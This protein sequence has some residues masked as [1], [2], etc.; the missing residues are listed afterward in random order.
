MVREATAW[1]TSG[2]PSS[3]I[4]STLAVE[5]HPA[6]GQGTDGGDHLGQPGGDLVQAAGVDAHLVA[7]AVDLHPDAVELGVDEGRQAGP[8]ATAAVGSGSL[9][10][11]IGCTAVPTS[12]PTASSAANP[13]AWSRAAAATVE[14]RSIAA[15]R[16]AAERDPVRR[17]ERVLDRCLRRPLP[18]LAEDQPRAGRAARPRWPGRTPRPRPRPAPPPNLHPT[19]R[20]SARTW[21]PPR[22]RSASPRQRAAGAGRAS[23]RRP[24]YAAGAASRSGRRR[25]SRG[26]RRG[27]RRPARP[28]SARAWR[29]GSWSRR[30]RSRSRPGAGAA[31]PDHAVRP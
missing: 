28:R 3:R 10:A 6:R 11:S 23:E 18:Q 17:R 9:A 26:R 21:R 27:P 7:V 16:T 4:A 31:W 22:P 2:R 12:S 14:E 13:P 24:S 5:H 29:S 15:R 30:A 25:R 20:R 19:A 1:N 8:R